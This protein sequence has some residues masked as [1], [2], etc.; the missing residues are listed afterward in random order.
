TYVQSLAAPPD[1]ILP[2]LT[3]LGE[4]AWADGWDPTILHAAPEPGAGTV[5]VTRH[6]GRADTLWLLEEYDPAR[7]RVRYVR[8]TP[9]SDVTEL[10]IA[11]EAAGADRTSATVSYTYTG[12]TPTGNALVDDM[13]EEHYAHRLRQ[14]ATALNHFLTTGQLLRATH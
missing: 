7:H 6:A 1:R 3:P 14:L 5:F 12:F 8:V 11:L 9:G 2:L 4:R 13:T 10:A